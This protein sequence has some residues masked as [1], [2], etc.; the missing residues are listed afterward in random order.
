MAGIDLDNMASS[1][2]CGSGGKGPGGSLDKG[3]E[4]GNGGETWSCSIIDRFSTFD[5][6]EGW[7]R[8]PGWLG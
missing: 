1:L 8:W 7:P 3:P 5:L 4:I 2:L 6:V